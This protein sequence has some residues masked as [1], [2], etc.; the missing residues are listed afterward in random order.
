MGTELEETVSF[1]SNGF[2][3]LTNYIGTEHSF[4]NSSNN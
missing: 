1:F 2:R 3:T 4:L